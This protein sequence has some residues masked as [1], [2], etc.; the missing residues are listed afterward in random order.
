MRA[1]DLILEYVQLAGYDAGLQTD[2]YYKSSLGTSSGYR[3]TP[4]IELK[5]G[6]VEA[7]KPFVSEWCVICV[8][9]IGGRALCTACMIEY[10]HLDVGEKGNQYFKGF[11]DDPNTL[12][13]MMAF[14]DHWYF[15]IYQ[16]D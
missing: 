4:F 12:P 10:R 5:K 11:I 15:R 9:T 16:E 1:C 8:I 2:Y 14:L 3:T 6:G 7:I 13:S